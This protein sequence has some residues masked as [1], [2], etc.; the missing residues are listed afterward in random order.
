MNSEFFLAAINRK[1]LSSRNG[2]PKRRVVLLVWREVLPQPATP[3]L[4][5]M[6]ASIRSAMRF[7][8]KPTSSCSRAG[9]PWVT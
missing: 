7:P 6:A 8:V 9:D 2:P 1:Y 4:S 5:A 3:S